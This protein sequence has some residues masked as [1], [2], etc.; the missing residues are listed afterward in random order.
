VTSLFSFT[1]LLLQLVIIYFPN[2]KS[3]CPFRVPTS[4]EGIDVTAMGASPKLG[5]SLIL[6]LHI[7]A[8]GL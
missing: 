8:A 3:N 6:P 5:A 2:P 4:Q 7:S 1:A